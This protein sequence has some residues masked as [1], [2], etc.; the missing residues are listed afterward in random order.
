M[1]FR[2]LFDQQRK[3]FYIGYN[4]DTGRLDSN[5]YDLLASEA[6][7]ASL[8]A[9]G[10]GNVPQSHWLYLARPL[11]QVGNTR[12]LLS[13]SGTMFEYLMPTLFLRSYHNTL[14]HQT[15]QA[16]VQ[17]HIDYG[18]EK[19]V[20][21]GISESGFYY[22]DAHQAYQYRA[23]GVPGLGYKRGLGD[24]LVVAPYASLMALPFEAQAVVQNLKLFQKLNVDGL[25]GLYEAIDFTPE[26]LGAGQDYAI[27]RSYMAHHQGMILVALDNFLSGNR[28][29]RRLH[30][31]LRI[32]NVELLL[33]EQTPQRAEIENPHLQD[34]GRLHPVHSLISLDPWT[35]SPT[36]P[37]PQ[38]HCLTNGHFNTL[39]TAAGSGYSH[40]RDLD[41]TRWQ[42]DTTLDNSGT[43]LYVR[44]N[45]SGE[46]WSATSQPVAMKAEPQRV[47][48][49]PHRA[50][51]QRRDANISIH[52]TVT[53]AAE[54][55]VEIRRITVTNH[56]DR[57]RSLSVTSYGEV[58]LAPQEV[59]RRHPAFNRLFIESDY[60]EEGHI[61]LFRRRSRSSKE[62]PVYLAHSVSIGDGDI[63]V[64]GVET[65]R[66]KFLGNG[67]TTERPAALLG[68]NPLSGTTGATLDPIFALQTKINLAP[69]Q[70]V[71]VAFL[72][73]ASPSR[74]ESI[75]L[76]RLYQRWEHV[77]Y[78]LNASAKKAE[79]EMMHLSLS[80]I[81]LEQ[82]Q[83][84]LSV[85]LYPFP[86]LRASP[87]VLAAN[88]LG[89]PGL[90]PFAI[91][92]DH[93]ILLV[94]IRDENGLDILTELL[95][96]HSYWRRRDQKIDL[97]ILNR[98]DTG[99]YD[100]LSEQ[101]RHL[102][103]RTTSD[104]WLNKHGGIFLLRED[105]M[106][107]AEITLLAT[108]ARVVLDD[109]STLAE[110]LAR[111]DDQPVRLPNFIPMREP[112]P[113]TLAD[114][115]VERPPDLLFDNGLG[116][117]T[118]DGREYVIYLEAGQWT[119]A[120][121]T[122]VIANP[123]FGFLV[124]SNGLGC[125]WAYNSGENRLTPW[126]NDP[127]SDPPSEA[128]YLRD[129]DN[130]QLWSPTPLPTRAD[131]PYL[132]RHG[133]GYSMFEHASHGLSQN[134]RVFAVPDEPV[135]IVQLKL[136]NLTSHTR[137]INITYYAEWVLGTRRDITAQYVI[138]EFDS[139]NF[140]LLARNPYNTE[141]AQNTAFL[142]ATRELQWV[143][144]DRTEF[145]GRLGNYTHPA[146]LGRVG[147]SANLQPGADPCAA[148]QVL[149]WLAPGE[150]KEVTFL[151]G[152]GT[153]RANTE[154][155]IAHYQEIAHVNE[156]WESVASFW[157]RILGAVRVRTPEPA[158]DL[159][160]N[161]W[162][163]YQALSCR[164]WGRTALHQSSGAFGFRDQ[165]QDVLAFM[166]ARPDLTRAHILEAASHQFE[167]GDVLHWWHPPSGRGIRSRISDNLLWLPFV[168][169][170]YVRET[171]DSS[172][173]TEVIPFLSAKALEE[174]EEERYGQ[175]SYGTQ[176][177]TL[178]EHCLRAIRKGVTRGAHGLPLIGAGDWNDGMNSVGD[179]GAGESVWLGWFIYDTLMRFARICETME[180]EDQANDLRQRAEGLKQALDASAWDGNWY[181]RAF[182]DDGTAL[183]SA[184][185]RECQID[186][187]SQSW[188][189]LSGA[190]DPERARI[191]M[192]SLYER[193]VR[194]QDAIILLLEPA[195]NLTLRNPGYIKAYPPGIRENGGQYTHA[196][197]WAI[198]AFA[199]LGQA[200]RAVE[201][202]RMI[203]PIF[204]ADTAEKA[205]HYKVEPYVVAADVYGVS[206]HT[207][208]GGWTWYTG[209]ASW[210]YRL[211]LEA[212]LGLRRAG[213]ELHIR[214]CIP[215][216]W[217]SF[218]IDYRFGSTSYH[219]RV[220][221][222][223][224]ENGQES[225]LTLDEKTVEASVVPLVDDGREHNVI[226]ALGK[227][228][229]RPE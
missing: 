229:A 197:T 207:G 50:D 126:R 142:A 205:A 56:T 93:P 10:K 138:P 62:K 218:E 212:I 187:I 24:D 147:L 216:D 112:V 160:L 213:D 146:S 111:L 165:L 88:S 9:I 43:W 163:L 44:D 78:A 86:A 186:S 148:M 103:T 105:Q 120:P 70:T 136:E 119:P 116:G 154:K 211:G 71:H 176:A 94:R 151:L 159:L 168:T 128:I 30:A 145:L 161:R 39:I 31:D 28:M 209:S 54:H 101:I 58:I 55:D 32:E 67:G 196:A 29:V 7:I 75:E 195:F 47:D 192:E 174:G 191:A 40:W 198:W 109:V 158:M 150:S 69:Y 2:F 18:K 12:A 177:G 65:D 182:F 139:R 222:N 19:G 225:R 72:T 184:E 115:G 3:V 221:N 83:K 162:L 53:V 87:E 108:A 117:F 223:P 127:V 181:I 157:D 48:F 169:A 149:L 14:L 141:F 123:E 77:L 152:Q 130:G 220:E 171:G 166:H 33:Q 188:A 97:V 118:P 135:K 95:T 100:D 121:W 27:V 185:R 114:G 193:L 201:L 227:V 49:F 189:V 204:H 156:A 96:A 202:F 34:V 46:L 5:H 124:T 98:S 17:R 217:L 90:W 208:R 21:W 153:D 102:F 6:R 92:G 224:D 64:S 143:T 57:K 26:R 63:T 215:A 11:T 79:D 8:V 132:I 179:K 45:E 13:W 129:E 110:Q 164:V 173:L 66:A 210:M 25:Y 194:P 226:L 42:P 35:V 22:L 172:I 200:E 60:V 140:A 134:V 113:S 183:G 15:C 80:S 144:T 41:L 203:N 1:D 20:P 206:P 125:T 137:R 36:A 170:N 52:T 104:K 199:E 180:N 4:V 51:F 122:N 106:A 214:P 82:A 133:A 68:S 190:G 37:Y 107:P 89:Q 228:T 84:L 167:E 81:D 131:A 91:S 99:Y 155:L 61:L 38:V 85:L 175:Y 219:I 59:D 23:F 76:A 74:K 178:Y 73:L 16:V